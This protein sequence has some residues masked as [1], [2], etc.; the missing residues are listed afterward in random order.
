MLD[1][2]FKDYSLTSATAAFLARQH[3][4]IIDGQSVAALSR[5]R[6]AIY[7]PASEEEIT[8]VAESGAEDVDLAVRAARAAFEGPWAK[9][10]PSQRGRILNRIADLI[11]ANGDE[12]AELECLNS[13][14]PLQFCRNVDIYGVADMFRYMAGWATKITGDTHNP[15]MPGEWHAY[16]LR[17]PVGVVGQILPWNF[18]MNMAAWKIAPALAAGCT[19]VLKP[20]EA[21]PLTALRI[22]ELAL[23]AGLPAGVLNVVTGK[24]SI[25]G[26]AITNHPG[27]DK[28]AFTGSTE[29]GKHIA[30]SCVSSNLKKVSL[31][32]GGKSP[33]IVFPDADI[34]AAVAGIAGSIFFHAGQVCA[35]GS[36]LYVH[37]K[38]YDRVVEAVAARAK[39][40]K[41]GPGMLPGHDLGPVI[42]RA[43]HESVMSY[44]E[45]GRGE[46]AEIVTGGRSLGQKGYFIEPTVLAN[47]GPGMTV[48]DEEIFGPVLCA[49]RFDEE[50]LAGI[51]A[52]ANASPYGL[53]SSVWTRD[54]SVAHRLAKMIQSGIVN[55]NAHTSPDAS[56]PYGGYKQSGWGRERGAEVLDLYTQTKA[57]AVKLA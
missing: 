17:Q 16:T 5:K 56:L 15:S 4:L 42:S 12:L 32:L 21:T 18:P 29:V 51:A 36:R 3:G 33:V 34:D 52:R 30:R 20:A 48:H 47:T 55:V 25:I 24:G 45:K 2:T 1:V 31:E 37:D 44:I 50:D 6:K 23:E 46:G 7:D 57:V 13:G 27:I 53:S 10:T 39:A 26:D 9:V 22:A 28:V 49:M 38:V 40:L 43:Q 35:A 41:I 14:K 11:E 54:I 19:I 8:T